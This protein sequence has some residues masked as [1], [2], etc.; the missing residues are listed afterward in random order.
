MADVAV[1]CQLGRKSGSTVPADRTGRRRGEGSPTTKK[2][3]NGGQRQGHNFSK[4]DR[5]DRAP[6]ERVQYQ[7]AGPPGQLLDR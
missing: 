1:S 5:T 7:R 4:A 3:E 6:Q 2:Y